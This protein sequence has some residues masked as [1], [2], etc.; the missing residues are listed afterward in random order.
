MLYTGP[1]NIALP[2]GD[3]ALQAEVNK[4]IKA[5]QDEGFIDALAVK[6]L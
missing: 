3:T 4:I 6:V 2:N 5:L 1:I